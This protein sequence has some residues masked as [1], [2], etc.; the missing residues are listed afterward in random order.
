[1]TVRP[2]RRS[3]LRVRPSRRSLGVGLGHLPVLEKGTFSYSSIK[4]GQKTS[5]LFAVMIVNVSVVP[6]EGPRTA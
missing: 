1:M 5:V 2:V 4:S 6:G 3:L